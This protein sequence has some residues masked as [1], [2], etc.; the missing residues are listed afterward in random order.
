[1]KN[2]RCT[3]WNL[4]IIG[5]KANNCYYYYIYLTAFFQDKD[6]VEIRMKSSRRG[7]Q[8]RWSR[9]KLAFFDQYLAISQKWCMLETLLLWKADRNLYVFFW[10]VLFSYSLHGA[11]VVSFGEIVYFC[12]LHWWNLLFRRC[13]IWSIFSSNGSI[14]AH[15]DG[16][17][18]TVNISAGVLLLFCYFI[19]WFFFFV[20]H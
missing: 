16:H 14:H 15:P 6:L 19:S 7:C 5:E 3:K 4:S 10:M 2:C 18:H 12:C 11:C 20:N 8:I 1:M 9:L 17:R 13:A